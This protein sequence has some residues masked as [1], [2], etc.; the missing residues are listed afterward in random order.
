MGA[1]YAVTAYIPV[2]NA[3][4]QG[5]HGKMY[6]QRQ[7]TRI[8]DLFNFVCIRHVLSSVYVLFLFFVRKQCAV[9]FSNK[10]IA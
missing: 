5:G 6:R 9:F 8:D 7:Y 1:K 10:L 2:T 3:C 4:K